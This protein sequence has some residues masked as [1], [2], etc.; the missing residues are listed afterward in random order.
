MKKT[1]IK[2]M[3]LTLVVVMACVVLASCGGP[4][5]DPDKA[6]EALEDAGYTVM[7]VDD[8][9]ALAFSGLK[10][11]T[12]AINAVNLEEEEAIIIYYFEDTEAANEAWEDVEKMAKEE[13]EEDE[14]YVIK[15][16]GKMI[17]FGTKEAVKAAK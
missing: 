14:D 5:A 1:I 16:S 15:K 2:I 4:N 17:Y 9:T 11:L 6:A 7:K 12:C 3:A 10:G 13:M 8:E